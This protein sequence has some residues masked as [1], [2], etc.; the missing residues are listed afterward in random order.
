M[1]TITNVYYYYFFTSFVN[2]LLSF[3]FYS[4]DVDKQKNLQLVN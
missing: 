4:S 1:A 2:N 3:K